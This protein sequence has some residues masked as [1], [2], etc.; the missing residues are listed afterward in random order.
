MSNNELL[1]T[2]RRL[3]ME[4]HE[5]TAG[6][7]SHATIN[8]AD[9]GR[10][11]TRNHETKKK[12]YKQKHRQRS[13]Y[14]SEKIHAMKREIDHRKLNVKWM[15][16][17]KGDPLDA[18]YFYR[19]GKKDLLFIIDYL[20]ENED[21]RIKRSGTIEELRQRLKEYIPKNRRKEVIDRIIAEMENTK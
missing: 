4:H 3:I 18:W 7:S 16:D 12:E 9:L 11:M 2:Y 13:V 10:I 15:E 17:I 1:S 8:I 20:N 21:M 5:L 6:A 14:L 19:M